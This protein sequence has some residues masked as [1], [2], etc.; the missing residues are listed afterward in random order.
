MSLWI[1]FRVLLLILCTYALATLYVSQSIWTTVIS[2]LACAVLLQA[3]YFGSVL[4]LVW[5][6]RD[7]GFARFWKSS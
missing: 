3:G 1:F 2:T 6:S 5:L 7:G 4:L